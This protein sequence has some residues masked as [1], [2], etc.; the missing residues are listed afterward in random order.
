VNVLYDASSRGNFRSSLGCRERKGHRFST[1]DVG[2]SELLF[3]ALALHYRQE[4]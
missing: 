3:F 1:S 4:G 2:A